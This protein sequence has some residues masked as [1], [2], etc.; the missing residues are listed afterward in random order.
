MCGIS[1]ADPV[2]ISRAKAMF[3]SATYQRYYCT[4]GWKK[5]ITINDLG[6]ETPCDSETEEEKHEPVVDEI[7]LF[8]SNQY[9]RKQVHLIILREA[10]FSLF[11]NL[12]ER[13]R[14]FPNCRLILSRLGDISF[15]K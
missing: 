2:V 9:P 8:I 15:S 1:S 4:C 11:E 10:V 13:A 3:I 6:W 14:D 7:I 5:Q 12:E